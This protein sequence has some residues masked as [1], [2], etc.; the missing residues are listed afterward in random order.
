MTRASLA[1]FS[2]RIGGQKTKSNSSSLQKLATISCKIM[3]NWI[4]GQ[5]FVTIMIIQTE[6][7]QKSFQ[8]NQLYFISWPKIFIIPDI[9]NYVVAEKNTFLHLKLETLK[10]NVCKA[11][12]WIWY[13]PLHHIISIKVYYFVK[14]R[15][16]QFLMI[17]YINLEIS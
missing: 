6:P 11:S 2:R 9:S 7:W 17:V 16:Y 15:H 4:S 1:I 13:K 8:C 14:W 5:D 10:L 3:I 12:N